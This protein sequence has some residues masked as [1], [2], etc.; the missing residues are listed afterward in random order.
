MP[1]QTADA[2]TGAVDELGEDQLKRL[3]ERI[4]AENGYSHPKVLSG[5]R[6]AVVCRFLTTDAIL[7]MTADHAELGYEDR[8]C[9]VHG[10]AVKALQAWNGEGE[11]QGWHRHPRTGR[12]RPDGDNKREYVAM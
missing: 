2:Q 9:Y 3:A 10:H 5:K 12:R 4:C 7:V 8:W 11:P 1:T 6:I